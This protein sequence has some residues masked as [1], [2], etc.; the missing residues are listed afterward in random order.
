MEKVEV[1]FH[2]CG[3]AVTLKYVVIVL[4]NA[5]QVLLVRHHLRTTWEIPGGHLELG[6]TPMQAAERELWEETG[7][8]EAHLEPLC[9]YTVD[10]QEKS[11]SGMLYWGIGGIS[12]PLPEFEIAQTDWF[13]Q[14]PAELTYPDIQPLLY[15]ACAAARAK[16]ADKETM[17]CL[18]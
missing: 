8:T 9:I 17:K 18:Q 1:S 10:Q 6:E 7:I 15:Q 2:P 14:L 3:A 12:G 16:A 13:A 4:F 11:D 5:D